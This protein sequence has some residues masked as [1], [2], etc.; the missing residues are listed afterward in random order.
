MDSCHRDPALW[1]WEIVR[2]TCVHN[3]IK[4]QFFI[5][6]VFGNQIEFIADMAAPARGWAATEIAPLL[7]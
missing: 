3:R 1:C 7:A 2:R 6:L 4:A 5:Q